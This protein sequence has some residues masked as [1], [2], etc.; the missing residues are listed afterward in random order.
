[1]GGQGP[2]GRGGALG[3]E[4]RGP[5]RGHWGGE[6]SRG[7]HGQVPGSECGPAQGGRA[8]W[9][10]L[11]T[12]GHNPPELALKAKHFLPGPNPGPGP[13]GGEGSQGGPSSST[14]RP[15]AVRAF[16]LLTSTSCPRNPQLTARGGLGGGPAGVAE[17]LEAA[18]LHFLGPCPHRAL[19]RGQEGQGQG[20]RPGTWAAS[21]SWKRRETDRLWTAGPEASCER[22]R[23]WFEP[24][25]PSQL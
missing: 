3:E 5:G 25:H 21:R 9:K 8:P 18:I 7:G 11:G 10:L 12:G 23:T 24:L 17:G 2:P 22:T 20:R 16:P 1:M 19:G 15:P 6:G 4:G 14:A 13:S